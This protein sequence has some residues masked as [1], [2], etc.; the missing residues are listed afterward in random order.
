MLLRDPLSP[1]HAV[2][3]CNTAERM[4][5]RETPFLRQSE[6]CGNVGEVGNEAERDFLSAMRVIPVIPFLWLIEVIRGRRR[7]QTRNRKCA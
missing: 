2:I 5:W 7:Q 4:K 1:R 6:F 3:R